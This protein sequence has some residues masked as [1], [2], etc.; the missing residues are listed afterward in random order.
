LQRTK[1][2]IFL[3]KEFDGNFFE[4]ILIYY[5]HSKNTHNFKVLG[6]FVIVGLFGCELILTWKRNPISCFFYMIFTMQECLVFLCNVTLSVGLGGT[7][8]NMA[9]TM[10]IYTFTHF[11][12]IVHDN[13]NVTSCI[14]N[15][16]TTMYIWYNVDA[17]EKNVDLGMREVNTIIFVR[18][19][20]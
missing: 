1:L 9:N 4:I 15:G 19:P 14:T 5:P 18:I 2:R 16:Q 12:T 8:L 20:F 13:K 11:T 3:I 10:I 7:L 6:S 17:N